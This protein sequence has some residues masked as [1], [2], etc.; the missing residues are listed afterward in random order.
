MNDQSLSLL[1]ITRTLFATLSWII[2]ISTLTS[3]G[4]YLRGANIE[5]I[6]Q[7]YI[8]SSDAD[9][10][11]TRELERFLRASTSSVVTN[12]DQAKLILQIHHEDYQ[13]L[14]LSISRQ[15]LVQEY[16]LIY[17]V[18][19]QIN[20]AKGQALTTMQSLKFS[21]DY[22][23]SDT[24]QVL[25]KGNEEHLLRQEI[26]QA[27]ARQILTHLLNVVAHPNN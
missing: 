24:N 8:D 23:F 15:L 21:R 20:D 2:I 5:D 26:L 12:R 10:G 3:C 7:L 16:E 17:T 13:R 6:P 19:F 9:L 22:S 25:G 1:N 18:T 11:I 4:F 14:P 27:A